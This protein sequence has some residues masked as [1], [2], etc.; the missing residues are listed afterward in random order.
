MIFY[1]WGTK[2]TPLGITDIKKCDRCGN[3]GPW[4]VYES[5]KQFKL[6]W[7]P[8]AQWNKHYAASCMTCP[9]T[10]E[11]PRENLDRILA[12][13]EKNNENRFIKAAAAILKSVA[14]V[15]GMQSKEWARA[16]E[17][18]ISISDD[19]ISR[20]EADNFLREATRRDLLPRVCAILQRYIA[21][22]AF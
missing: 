17:H 10:W 15:G 11:I 7:I 4:L 20:H 13:G 16:I 6:Y 18:L 1:Q 3:S 8:V 5:K 19:T 14:K 12:E 21:Y 2:A 9:N 22:I